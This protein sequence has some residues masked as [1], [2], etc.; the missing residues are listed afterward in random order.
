MYQTCFLTC[1]VIILNHRDEIRAGYAPVLDFHSAH[2]ASK[3]A[4]LLEKIHRRT[5]KMEHSPKMVK[6]GHAAIIK[7]RDELSKEGQAFFITN[8]ITSSYSKN[9]EKPSYSAVH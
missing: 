9:Q 5:K 2:I 4:Q 7:L 8:H 1:Q 3:F 6:S